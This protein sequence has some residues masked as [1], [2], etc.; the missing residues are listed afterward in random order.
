MTELAYMAMMGVDIA[1]FGRLDPY[2]HP[3]V[4]ASLYRIVGEAAESNAIPWD[5]PEKRRED[6]GDGFY[7]LADIGVID[8]VEDLVVA[9]DAGLRRH[10]RRAPA[11]QRVTLR[12]AFHTGFVQHD[13]EG[14]TGPDPLLLFRLLDSKVLKEHLAESGRQSAFAI[15][16]PAHHAA[17]QRRALTAADYVEVVVEEKETRERAWI[18]HVP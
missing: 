14:L 18:R 12:M 15:S 11:E 16:A 13:E 5:Q 17:V 7:L 3:A 10:N 4:R 1:G 9:I 8:R 6:R 2:V